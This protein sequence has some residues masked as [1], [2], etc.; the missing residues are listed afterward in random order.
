MSAPSEALLL[1]RAAWSRLT[2]PGDTTA[3]ALVAA[4][5]PEEALAWLRS[6]AA[7][8]GVLPGL[9]DAD[10]RLRTAAARWRTRLATLDPRRELRI[11]ERLGGWLLVP[12]APGWPAGLDDLGPAAP[13]CLWVR[14]GGDAAALLARSIAIVGARACTAYGEHVTG[15]LAAGVSEAGWTVVSGG[16]Y[17][18]DATAHRTALMCDQPT[19]AFL[20]GGVDRLYPAGNADLLAGIAEAGVLVAEVPPGS[21]PAKARFLQRNRLI[22]AVSRAT[23]VVEAAWR[24]GAAST[25]RH[26]AEL[27]R[28]VGAV[29]GPVTSAASAG[30]H[31]L[32]RDGCAVCV[33]DAAEVLELVGPVPAPEPAGPPRP[34]DD[35]PPAVRATLDAL[36]VRRAADEESL[37]RA[38]GLALR[39]VRAALGRLELAGLARREGDRWRRAGR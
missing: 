8:A 27:L 28:P 2:E 12:E 29:P 22:A 4:L 15:E 34:G 17:G 33:T 39:E 3:G 25:A 10:A 21:V 37:A 1:A 13:M 32:I 16:A 23:V 24:S 35:L 11:L 26:A 19:V 38:A 31:R 30:C 6:D 18:I 7:A 20:A 36:P 9:T 5:G 14:G